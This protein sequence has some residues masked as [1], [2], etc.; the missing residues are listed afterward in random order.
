[1]AGFEVVARMQNF[2]ITVVER[3]NNVTVRRRM[4]NWYLLDRGMEDTD[5]FAWG[6]VGTGSTC[7]AYSILREFLGKEGADELCDRFRQEF[8]ERLDQEKGFRI[9]GESICK[10]LGMDPRMAK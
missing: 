3:I 2:Q 5:N 9:T 4:R 7:T 8:V 1:M 6:Y 10:I